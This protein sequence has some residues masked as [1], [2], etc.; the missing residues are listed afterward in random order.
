MESA[1]TY[2]VSAHLKYPAKRGHT[3]AGDSV[4]A[5]HLVLVNR[6]EVPFVAYSEQA[7]FLLGV[8]TG[9]VLLVT[10]SIIQYAGQPT[11]KVSLAS[12]K[13]ATRHEPVREEH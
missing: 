1:N 2:T 5:G 11:L 4:V 10:G 3:Q 7:D 12:V 9:D 8:N 6:A 13:G